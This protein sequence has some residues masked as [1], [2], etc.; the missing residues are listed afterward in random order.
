MTEIIQFNSSLVPEGKYPW[1]AFIA[2]LG[3][4]SLG[5]CGA[6]F[7]TNQHALT[8]KG[9]LRM[10]FKIRFG[11]NDKKKFRSATVSNITIHPKLD[12]DIAILTLSEPIKVH[13][14]CLPG[15]S[16]KYNSGFG[17][18]AGWGS[19]GWERSELLR[20][21]TLEIA[22]YDEYCKKEEKI[23]GYGSPQL[24]S[25]GYGDDGGPFMAKE[26]GGR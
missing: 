26:T 17:V 2:G 24:L 12:I 10:R 3:G 9:C 13:T 20:E 15:L 25:G 5:G 21:T 7:I 23:C 14:I 8:S 19:L 16:V 6:S 18:A 1:M 22:K 4:V 11:S